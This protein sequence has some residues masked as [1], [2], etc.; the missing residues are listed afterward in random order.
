MKTPSE[1]TRDQLEGIVGR[2]Q[3]ILWLDLRR[4]MLDPDLSWDCEAVEQVAGVLQDAGLKPGGAVPQQT[5]AVPATPCRV[6]LRRTI[7][8]KPADDPCDSVGFIILAGTAGSLRRV[9]R[10]CRETAGWEGARLVDRESDLGIG[11]IEFDLA[12]IWNRPE[13]LPLPDPVDPCPCNLTPRRGQRRR[14][15]VR[16]ERPARMAGA[17]MT[18]SNRYL[19]RSN[20]P[21]GPVGLFRPSPFERFKMDRSRWGGGPAPGDRSCPPLH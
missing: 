17:G 11:H 3:V 19:D 20:L 5:S 8:C 13:D 12:L 2:I 9:A 10:T 4:G 16:R 18:P 6:R 14:W 7:S 1:L 15:L 21:G